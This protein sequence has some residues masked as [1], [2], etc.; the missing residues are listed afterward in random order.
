MATKKE[1]QLESGWYWIR[2]D[3]DSDKW[4]PF[5]H[6]AFNEWKVVTGGITT[7]I[8]KAKMRGLFGKDCVGRKVDI[9]KDRIPNPEGPYNMVMVPFVVEAENADYSIMLASRFAIIS[10]N[11][12]L[13][14]NM[15]E[16]FYINY[17]GIPITEGY[18]F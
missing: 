11:L 3:K 16:G 8:S 18:G 12:T 9:E 14:P 15:M 10:D 17:D 2:E 5:F 13:P 1:D 6:N 7:Y 4:R